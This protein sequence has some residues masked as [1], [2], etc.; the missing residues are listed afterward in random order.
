VVEAIE[1]ESGG[2]AAAVR[3]GWIIDSI[4]GEN[5]QALFATEIDSQKN[6]R[7]S[8]IREV[9]EESLSGPVGSHVLV[10]FING[11]A[12]NVTCD[13]ERQKA[14]GELVTFWNLPPE[15]VRKRLGTM[16]GRD[17]TLNFIINPRLHAY[18][19]RV[20]VVV[21]GGSASTSE[22]LAQGLQDLGRARIFGTRTAG[23]PLPSNIIRL[24]NGD[25]FQYPEGNYTSTKGRVLEGN[26]VEPDVVVAPSI[27][28]LLAGRDLPLEAAGAW[29]GRK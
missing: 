19:G 4:G 24:P 10:R 1:R 16:T 15:R 25:R 7:D 6:R 12:K 21:N 20:A 9:V 27:Q 3:P 2:A 13:I 29:C 22:I 17:E 28:A 11:E 5:V 23:A 8:L 14:T 18:E 26:G